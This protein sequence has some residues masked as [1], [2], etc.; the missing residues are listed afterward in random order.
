MT[1]PI[2]HCYWCI[3]W[4]AL[5]ES[6]FN[7][8]PLITVLY[9]IVWNSFGTIM[10]ST[11]KSAQ[12]DMED[13]HVAYERYRVISAV[14]YQSGPLFTKRTDVLPTN[15]VKPRS[16]EIECYN[17]RIALKI[18]RHLGS[19]AAEV[20]VLLESD[21]KSLNPILARFCD[22][23]SVRWVNRG[24]EYDC[25]LWMICWSTFYTG[26][27]NSLR[28]SDPYVHRRTMSRSVEIMACRLSDTKPLPKSNLKKKKN[29]SDIRY[30]CI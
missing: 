27:V 1:T 29:F 12:D 9:E 24:P 3:I 26:V 20:P 25:F 28:S 7:G 11:I 4:R 14:V 18:D 17:H 30:Q 6:I 5:P 2:N 23:R 19:A 15:L 22:M 21:W 16:R 13:H 10:Q 8:I